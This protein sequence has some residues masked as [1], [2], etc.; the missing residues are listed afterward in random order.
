MNQLI[1]FFNTFFSYLLVM[2]VIVVV[3]G[4]ATFIG[5]KMRKNKN[6]Q[7]ENAGS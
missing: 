3:A 4:I 7:V 2:A 6:K 5:I 1:Y